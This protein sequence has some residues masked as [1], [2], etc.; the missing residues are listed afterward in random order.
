MGAKAFS[1]ILGY[2]CINAAI[3]TLNM[4]AILPIYREA[5]MDPSNILSLFSLDVFTAI[6]GAV[7]GVVITILALMTRSYALS[8]GVLLLWIVGIM[9]KPIQDV[10]VGL[11]Y[12][13]EQIFAEAP[14]VGLVISQVIVAFAAVLLFTFI[15]EILAGRDIWG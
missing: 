1:L 5:T 4:L 15:V 8:T 13:L 11:P 14:Y 2:F 7:G 6:T 9:F 3:W 12:L 10:F